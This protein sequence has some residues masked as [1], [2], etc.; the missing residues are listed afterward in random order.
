ML[1]MPLRRF[2][3]RG[4]SQKSECYMRDEFRDRLS[5]LLFIIER[6]TGYK[7]NVDHWHDDKLRK[8]TDAGLRTTKR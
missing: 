5:V 3:I 4:L 2:F 8:V 7:V 1:S 6:D